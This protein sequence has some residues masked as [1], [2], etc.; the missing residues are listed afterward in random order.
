MLALTL[1]DASFQ[2]ELLVQI[3]LLSGSSKG[4]VLVGVF[5][6]LRHACQVC[7]GNGDVA[8]TIRAYLDAS[9]Q[10]AISCTGG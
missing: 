1:S 6:N 3:V 5:Y 8:D 10:A 2:P 9:R 7:F 4:I